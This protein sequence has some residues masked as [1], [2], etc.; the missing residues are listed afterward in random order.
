MKL[1]GG[2]GRVKCCV[3]IRE[4]FIRVLY[5]GKMLSSGF[6][7]MIIDNKKDRE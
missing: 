3:G 7:E 4:S 6:G 1:F 5:E 2:E